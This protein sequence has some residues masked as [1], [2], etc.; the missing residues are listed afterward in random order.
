VLV[1]GVQRSDR[2]L[3]FT[4]DFGADR[5]IVLPGTALGKHGLWGRL[6]ERLTPRQDCKAEQPSKADAPSAKWD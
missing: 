5:D 2:A 6:Q 3:G 4:W 1:I